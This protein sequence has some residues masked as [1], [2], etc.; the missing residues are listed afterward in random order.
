VVESDLQQAI[1]ITKNG[2][3]MKTEEVNGKPNYFMFSNRYNS[4]HSYNSKPAEL[5]QMKRKRKAY[6][7]VVLMV[8]AA[9]NIL[10]IL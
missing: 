8:F 5:I 2:E 7:C 3:A 10:Y 9:V 1:V 6:Y 4:L